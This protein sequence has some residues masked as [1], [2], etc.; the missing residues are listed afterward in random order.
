M[1]SANK[2]GCGSIVR[3]NELRCENLRVSTGNRDKS[4]AQVYKA[5]DQEDDA[6]TLEAD[7]QEE[8]SGA[9]PQH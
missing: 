7:D 1:I 2:E 9:R 5:G 8:D 4:G 6:A 3:V